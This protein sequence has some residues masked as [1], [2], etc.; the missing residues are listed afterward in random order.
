MSKTTDDNLIAHLDESMNID[1]DGA[2]HHDGTDG[3]VVDQAASF[4][5]TFQCPRCA[6]S[7]AA[8]LCQ[9]RYEWLQ[10]DAIIGAEVECDS[11]G[12]FTTLT[13]FMRNATSIAPKVRRARVKPAV[14]KVRPTATT[15]RPVPKT[16][17][18]AISWEDAL[19]E[20]EL[21]ERAKN[22]AP[23][24]IQNRAWSLSA[25]GRTLGKLP[26]GVTT[27]DLRERL[28][29]G[30]GAASMRSETSDY[31]AF[32]SFLLDNEFLREDPAAALPAV[33]A[34]KRRPRPYTTGE[35]EA[36]LESGG[37]A[38]TKAMILLAFLQGFRANEV[39]AVHGHDVDLAA[40][41][42]RVVGKAGK[43]S[44]LPLHPAVREVAET[45][46]RDD[47]WFPARRGAE[48]HIRSNSV[49]DL[50]KRA[51]LRAG[52]TNRRLTGHSLRH[53]FGTELVRAGVDLRTVQEL[54][55]H[56][57]L[58]TTELYTEINEEQMRSGIDSLQG[59]SK[60]RTHRAESD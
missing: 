47:W 27:R 26:A 4:S 8:L 49:S 55:R 12:S 48:G 38:H 58:Q 17:A 22:L 56:E 24:T 18:P 11:C 52:I 15:S 5:V 16:I 1:C 23:R 20:F 37:Y 32:F 46:P 31:K 57:T 34:P 2:G 7:A 25:T 10:R 36:L 13:A 40:E 29:R 59:L 50:M 28:A 54:M 60:L 53:S 42:I 19:A 9:G 43:V 3:H 45:M 30:L 51:K 44:T 14:T 21:Y 6:A 41:T 35:I 39:A 33:R